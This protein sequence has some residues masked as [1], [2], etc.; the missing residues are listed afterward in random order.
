MSNSND[1][2]QFNH[3]DHVLV[4]NQSGVIHTGV[5]MLDREKFLADVNRCLKEL[6]PDNQEIQDVVLGESARNPE[7]IAQEIYKAQESRR[8]QNDPFFMLLNWLKDTLIST[9]G[10]LR[11][12]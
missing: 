4:V 9:F 5:Y 11:V 6:H 8:Q 7:Q 2:V 10:W 3:D 12:I 1:D